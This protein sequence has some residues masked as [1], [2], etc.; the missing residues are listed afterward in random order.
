M[1]FRYRGDPSMWAW[2]L[3]RVT[4]VGIFFFLLV[5]VVDTALISL[6]RDLF[7]SMVK[8]YHHP[9][10]RVGEVLLF[11]AVLFHG[12][13]GL[14]IT[15]LDFAPQTAVYNRQM[16][17]GIVAIFILIFV[18]VAFIMVAQTLKVNGVSELG[19]TNSGG[20]QVWLPV[21]IATVGIVSVY[22]PTL[23][24][25][26]LRPSVRPAGGLEFYGWLF[27]RISGLLLIFLVLGHLTVMHLMH[28]G[29]YR[30]NYDFVAQRFSSLFWRTY[31][32]VLL[33]LAI[34]HGTWG[35]RNVLLDYIHRPFARLLSLSLLYTIVGIVLSLGALLLFTFQPR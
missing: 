5:H 4:G 16:L 23:N 25:P 21:L 12:I 30:I 31:D 8:L 34:G 14:R 17:V 24:M 11:G 7:N 22:A 33:V 35:M 3:H 18:P 20:W 10:F 26:Q 2:L 29:V 1:V 28:G 19:A 6:G 9:V 13:N 27:T 15:I 32:F